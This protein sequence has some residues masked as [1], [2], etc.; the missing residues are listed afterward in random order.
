MRSSSNYK[1]A[2]WVGF[3]IHVIFV[4]TRTRILDMECINPSCTTH[5][6]ADM[7]LS[8]LYLPMPNVIIIIASFTLGSL[9]WGLYFI[10]LLWALEKVI[11]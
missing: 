8:I 1:L 5:L 11:K 6:I 3:A 7:P 10:G 9:L 2:F 4:W